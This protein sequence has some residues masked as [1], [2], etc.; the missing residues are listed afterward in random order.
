MRALWLAIAVVVVSGCAE[1]L[2]SPGGAVEAFTMLPGSTPGSVEEQERQANADANHAAELKRTRENAAIRETG[3]RLQREQSA[4]AREPL[5]ETLPVGLTSSMISEAVT[6]VK[7]QVMACRAQSLS[8]GQVMVSVKVAADG[9]VAGVA[10]MTTPAPSLGSCVRTAVER[11]T[12]A[13][14]QRGG[15]FRYPFVF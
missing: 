6:T 8:K 5:D 7:T 9:H 13:K 2:R 3:T 10:V 11:A 15:S 4:Q 14:T 12:F 1:I